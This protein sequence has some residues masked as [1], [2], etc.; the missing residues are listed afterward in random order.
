MNQIFRI[1]LRLLLLQLILSAVLRTH[2]ILACHEHFSAKLWLGSLVNGIQ[3]DLG[4]GLIIVN[5]IVS[6]FWVTNSRR[7]ARISAIVLNGVQFILSS[8]NISL[9]PN[10]NSIFSIRVMKYI[11]DPSEV[12]RNSNNKDFLLLAIGL[13]GIY[14]FTVVSWKKLIEIKIS[15][16]KTTW[17][18]KI[19]LTILVLG[20][21]FFAL[22]RGIRQIPLNPSDAYFCP[23]KF[24]NISSIN[25][26]WNF[27]HVLVENQ[28][29]GKTN[30]YHKLESQVAN[31]ILDE[32]L[33]EKPGYFI[34]PQLLDSSGTPP[35]I[36]L[37]TMEGI[38]ASLIADDH[39]SKLMPNLIQFK[40]EAYSFEKA[41]ASGFRTEQGLC[42]LL[43]GWMATPYNNITDNISTLDQIPSILS[44]FRSRNY[45]TQFIFGGD[46]E[47]ANMK[48]YLSQIGFQK[49]LSRKEFNSRECT[50]KLGAHDA[51][52]FKKSY[53]EVKRLRGPYF[54]QILTQ[55][56]H[57][58]FDYPNH[59]PNQDPDRAYEDAARYLDIQLGIFLDSLK[60][61]DD[62]KNT[63]III[64]SDHSHSYPK[65]IDIA[66]LP[67]FHIPLIIHSPL[68]STKYRGF[69]DSNLFAQNHFPATLSYM[70]GFR[71]KNYYRYS[72]NHFSN[73]SKHTFSAFVNGYVYQNDSCYLQ[74]DY[75]WR[76]FDTTE[77]LKKLHAYPMSLLQ[78]LTEDIRSEKIIKVRGR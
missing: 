42:A 15:N 35:N 10:W 64:T 38:S 34:Y 68:L 73:S 50:Q 46:I 65:T 25:A 43:S 8:I 56:T 41:Y 62:Y 51:A 58:P 30:P 33:L 53:T 67:R 75:T 78:T 66:E 22:R 26:T 13:I 59:N 27:F 9:Y 76:K 24:Y 63:I 61:L 14:L 48:A 23:N 44:S 57:Q 4:I 11:Y 17:I 69:K 39:N 52:L 55:S 3:F 47:F 19:I 12:L 1:Y 36:I 60:S 2:F 6:S 45:T 31:R 37:I 28:M 20:L 7:I 70:L 21:G 40:K 32:L 49:I 74:Y 71:E 16:T 54:L 72:L 18:F 29:Y 5:L 77:A